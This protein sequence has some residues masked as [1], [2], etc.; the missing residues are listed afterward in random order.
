MANSSPNRSLVARAAAILTNAEVAATRIDLNE[1][2]GGQVSVQVDFTIGSLTNVILKG[3]VSD[4]G[5]TYRLVSAE[6]AVP[7][8][9]TA[10]LTATATPVLVFSGLGGWKYFRVSA[11]GT[12]TVTSSSLALKY[13]YLRRASQ[14]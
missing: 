13:R 11:E 6:V 1:C 4:D 9:M 3:Y 8:A 5:T 10:T 7:T 14:G 12:G 2:W